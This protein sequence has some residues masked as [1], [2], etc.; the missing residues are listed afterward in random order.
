M[1]IAIDGT[2]PGD[3]TSYW[4]DNQSSHVVR[5][6]R[7]SNER[8]KAYFRGP[9]WDGA[10]VSRIVSDARSWIQAAIANDPQDLALTLVGHSRGALAVLLVA[11]ELQRHTRQEGATSGRANQPGARQA[12]SGAGVTLD[13][14][15]PWRQFGVTNLPTLADV[16]IRCAGLFD[17]VDNYLSGDAKYVPS[18]IPFCFHAVRDPSVCSRPAFFNDGLV[19]EDGRA[20][21]LVLRYFSGTHAALGGTPW[22]GDHPTKSVPARTAGGLVIGEVRNVPTITEAQDRTTSASVY[23]WML[24]CLVSAKAIS[25]DPAVRDWNSKFTPCA[26]LNKLSR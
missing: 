22:T 24:A 10:G 12:L 1:L 17:C 4:A 13:S 18:N 14:R 15:Q 8:Q 23:A 9:I 19:A 11:Q 25:S 16:S 3:S 7:E 6:H 2:G 26:N 5:V 21:K 20:T